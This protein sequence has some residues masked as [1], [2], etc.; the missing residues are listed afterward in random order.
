MS[1]AGLQGK[2][3]RK[4]KHTT[5]QNETHPVTEDLVHR[6]FN[7]P[8]LNTVWAADISFLPTKEE[9]LYLAVI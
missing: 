9:W 8:T 1:A 5:T 7:V 6:S 4:H 2:D 3:R